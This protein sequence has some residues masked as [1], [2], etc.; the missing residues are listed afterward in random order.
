MHVLH[1]TWRKTVWLWALALPLIVLGCERKPTA[2]EPPPPVAS[3]EVGPAVDTLLVGDHAQF[4]A[5]L[6]DQGGAILSG[7]RIDWSIEQPSWAPP[8]GV[9]SVDAAGRVTALGSPVFGVVEVELRATSEG[10][11]GTAQLVIY[12]RP[13][14][15]A[16]YGT[17]RLLV[18]REAVLTVEFQDELG[19]A[20]PSPPSVRW[21]SSDTSALSVSSTGTV[22]GRNLGRAVIS[23]D[24]PTAAGSTIEID[25]V[26]RGYSL[27]FL[28]SP[29]DNPSHPAAINARGQVVGWFPTERLIPHAFLW[30]EGVIHDLGFGEVRSMALALNDRGEIAG[31]AGGAGGANW[32]AIWKDGI[33]VHHLARGGSAVAINENGVALVACG[34]FCGLI[35]DGV[36]TTRVV[37]D[38]EVA[39]VTDLTLDTIVAGALVD[40]TAPL[41][42]SAAF[43][44]RAGSTKI[45]AGTAR[46]I[47]GSGVVIGE[48]SHGGRPNVFC[49]VG[50]TCGFRWYMGELT[51]LG[52]LG[53]WR[54]SPTD[55]NDLG[56]IVGIDGGRAFVW[57]D[58]SI[59][60]L[61]ALL[62]HPEWRART[63]TGINEAGWIVGQVENRHTGR[64]E[65][66]VFVPDP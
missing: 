47:N 1:P 38:H 42:R 11:T 37:T 66:V 48:E 46:R 15:A 7:R 55:L 32:P 23:A 53:P 56:Q 9:A 17:E 2:P 12:P 61:S 29:G 33:L 54:V 34:I 26:D 39:E 57:S 16:L 50:R 59:A 13:F 44:T 22:L 28:G 3:V 18:G 31:V 27:T 45:S 8:S 35:W 5:V 62:R 49:G 10:I 20:I 19:R 64:I 6:R 41:A 60:E 30:E 40:I 4:T 21:T 65:G 63:A 24:L 52:T 58:D 51:N 14:Q 25:V 43:W 36:D